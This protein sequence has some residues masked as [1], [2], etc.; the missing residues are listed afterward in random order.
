MSVVLSSALAGIAIWKKA[1]TPLGIALAWLM[2][3]LICEIGGIVAFLILAATFLVTIIADKF[4]GQ[5][6]DPNGLRRKSGRRDAVRVLCN[7]GVGTA[8]ILLYGISGKPGPAQPCFLM[9]FSAVMAESLSD[10]LAS[11]LGPL[12][13]GKTVDICTFRETSVGLSGG[14]SGAGSVAAIF[15][16]VL[17]G[18]ICMLFHD[19]DVTEASLVAVIGYSG[20]LFD[21][22][23]GSVAQAKYRCPVC[24]MVTERDRHCGVSTVLYKGLRPINNDAVNLLSN[25]FSAILAIIIL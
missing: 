7:V 3:F 9:T 21:S 1:L 6:A 12:T 13:R 23:M 24:G 22:V 4:A 5:R 11:K 19:V 2:C 15:G 14:V 25:L 16:A 10:S 17:I 20:C 8:M 18:A